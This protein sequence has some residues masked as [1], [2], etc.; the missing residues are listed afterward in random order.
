[1]LVMLFHERPL[2]EYIC[3]PRK[4]GV[5]D[6]TNTDMLASVGGSAVYRMLRQRRWFSASM[7]RNLVLRTAQRSHIGD[8]VVGGVRVEPSLGRS[9]DV[10]TICYGAAH[11]RPQGLATQPRLDPHSPW[12]G[13]P[14]VCKKALQTTLLH[15]HLP[16]M[17]SDM[18]TFCA[19]HAPSTWSPPLS[20]TTFITTTPHR[21]ILKVHRRS[22]QEKDFIASNSAV[23]RRGYD[24]LRTT[25]S[26]RAGGGLVA[27]VFDDVETTEPTKKF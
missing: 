9:T 14:G 10:D 11:A 5:G 15:L 25:Y 1:M 19:F 7:K 27:K 8:V 23:Q 2:K 21:A 22:F 13:F 4:G 26:Q 17:G 24:S 6:V 20:L 12:G 18:W 16:T 3:H